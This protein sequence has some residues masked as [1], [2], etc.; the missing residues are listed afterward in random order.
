MWMTTGGREEGGREEGG[1]EE[2]GREEGGREEGGR[3]EGGREE[4][5][6]E[7]GGREEG[8]REEGRGPT[9]KTMNWIIRLSALPQTLAWSKLVVFTGNKPAFEL[10]VYIFAN[11]GPSPPTSTN[12]THDECSRP[13]RS[14]TP[15]YYCEQR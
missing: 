8:G 4:G 7:E 3:E 2:G 9:A 10:S 11:I 13:F 5:G 14:S 1:R 6:C 15:V 12:Q